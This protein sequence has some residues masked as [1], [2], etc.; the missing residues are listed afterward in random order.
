MPH[1]VF[2][3]H[4]DE[5]QRKALEQDKELL[6]NNLVV[7]AEKVLPIEQRKQALEERKQAAKSRYQNDLVQVNG[8]GFRINS[9]KIVKRS[10][11]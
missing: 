7:K 11:S 4:Y 5:V 1:Y 8:F 9:A 2:E 6:S 10:A 3:D